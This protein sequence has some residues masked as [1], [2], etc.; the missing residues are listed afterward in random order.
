MFEKCNEPIRVYFFTAFLFRVV[1]NRGRAAAVLQKLKNGVFPER[2]LVLNGWQLK[3][4]VPSTRS[5]LLTEQ[6]I[7]VN[8]ASP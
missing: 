2:S 8:S 1:A 7:L 6:R 5:E 3:T 4:L